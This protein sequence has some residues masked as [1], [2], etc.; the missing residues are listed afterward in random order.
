MLP[1]R[2]HTNYGQRSGVDHDRRYTGGKA[3]HILRRNRVERMK[4][5][6]HPDQL[7]LVAVEVLGM[8]SRP[9]PARFNIKDTAEIM[10]TTKTEEIDQSGGEV[11]VCD[12]CPR[13]DDVSF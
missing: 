1:N 9:R 5:L 13:C 2:M 8:H 11:L 12:A 3:N 6:S 10:A 7:M 4:A